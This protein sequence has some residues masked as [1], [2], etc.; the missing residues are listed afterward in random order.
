MPPFRPLPRATEAHGHTMRALAL[1]TAFSLWMMPQTM[2]ARAMVVM[3]D[4]LGSCPAPVNEEE[5]HHANVLPLWVIGQVP[6]PRHGTSSNPPHGEEKPLCG[7]HGEV[8]HPPP[9]ARP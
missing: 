1:F 6:A 9:W 2:N 7:D 4:D 8:P 3:P 5:V